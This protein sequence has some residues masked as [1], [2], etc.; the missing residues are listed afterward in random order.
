MSEISGAYMCLVVFGQKTFSC[1]V[2]FIIPDLKLI[3]SVFGL[4]PRLN[5]LPDD[6]AEEAYDVARHNDAENVEFQEHFL[7][8]LIIGRLIK[9]ALIIKH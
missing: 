2:F 7:F 1:L 5:C 9:F 4:F 8:K 6:E 3:I